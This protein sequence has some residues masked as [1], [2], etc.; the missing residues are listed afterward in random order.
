MGSGSKE[1]VCGLGCDV[2]GGGGGG[3]WREEGEESEHRQRAEVGSVAS[4]LAGHLGHNYNPC[5]Q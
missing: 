3:G 5:G 2:I 1:E 4:L